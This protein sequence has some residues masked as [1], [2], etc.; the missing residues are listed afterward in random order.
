MSKGDG[1]FA[2]V[3]FCP[4]CGVEA[5]KRDNYRTEHKG[6]RSSD[7]ITDDSGPPEFVCE[8]CGFAFRISASLRYRHAEI[9]FKRHRQLRPPDDAHK[10]IEE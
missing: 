6:E 4:A 5:L 7:G 10:V 1:R 8:I 3:R 2:K 9:Y